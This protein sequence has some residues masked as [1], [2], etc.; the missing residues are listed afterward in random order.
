M[1]ENAKFIIL[2]MFFIKLVYRKIR[3]PEDSKEKKNDFNND[4]MVLPLTDIPSFV[5]TA[6]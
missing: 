6:L 3:F 2:I 1:E 5:Q 4:M